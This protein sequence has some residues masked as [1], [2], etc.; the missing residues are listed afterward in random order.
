MG[1][2]EIELERDQL[3]RIF[4]HEIKIASGPAVLDL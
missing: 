3:S 4:L 2:N 1:N